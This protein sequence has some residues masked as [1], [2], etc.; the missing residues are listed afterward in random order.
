MNATRK[1]LIWEHDKH[2]ALKVMLRLSEPEIWIEHGIYCIQDECNVSHHTAKK[3]F[4][5]WQKRWNFKVNT[6][7][8]SGIR[9]LWA[10]RPMF[11][12]P[13]YKMSELQGEIKIDADQY[14]FELPV[15]VNKK[16]TGISWL[17]A[18][19]R[20]IFAS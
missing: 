11:K 13:L 5:Y 9:G 4:K 14:R 17:L 3:L 2:E 18:K 16:L 8:D 12:I 1:R 15:P 19:L 10:M 6:V 7:W 20:H